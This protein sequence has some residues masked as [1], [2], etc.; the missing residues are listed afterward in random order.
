M[1]KNIAFVVLSILCTYSVYA[2]DL[3]GMICN[4][5]NK[6]IEM[7]NVMISTPGSNHITAVTETSANGNFTIRTLKSGTYLE[8][9]LLK[10][11]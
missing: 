7:V 9:S 3:S 1:K 8:T 2:G 10:D 6:P 11:I 5:L 4:E